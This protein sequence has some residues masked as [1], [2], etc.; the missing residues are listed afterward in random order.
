MSWLTSAFGTVENMVGAGQKLGVAPTIP[1]DFMSN[2]TDLQNRLNNIIQLG[3]QVKSLQ[4][5][6]VPHTSEAGTLN[7]EANNALKLANQAGANLKL[8]ISKAE[9]LNTMIHAAHFPTP[10]EVA[11]YEASR[12]VALFRYKSAYAALK[13]TISN[14]NGAAQNQAAASQPSVM[15]YVA[16]PL[17]GMLN[18]PSEVASGAQA[19]AAKAETVIGKAATVAESW[20]KPVL[21]GGAILGGIYIFIYGRA[22]RR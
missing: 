5:K 8:A 16:A 19:V 17:Q 2:L 12:Q 10:G 20:V 13:S 15:S 14:I 4:A 11:T 18:L 3:Y 7:A 22:S 21:I 6:S 1:T 9:N